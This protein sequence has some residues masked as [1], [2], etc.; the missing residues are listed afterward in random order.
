MSVYGAGGTFTESTDYV[1][2]FEYCRQGTAPRALSH[3]AFSEGRVVNGEFQYDMKDHLGNV[4]LSFKKN[5]S[6]NADIVQEDLYYPFGLRVPLT[7]GDNKYLY[8][9]KE[10]VNKYDLNWYHYGA[11][12]YDPQL[13]RWHTMDPADQFQSPYEYVGNDPATVVDPDGAQATNAK[14]ESLPSLQ[15]M[16]ETYQFNQMKAEGFNLSLDFK[17]ASGANLLVDFTQ[18]SSD[19]SFSLGVGLFALGF[20]TDGATWPFAEHAFAASLYASAANLGIRAYENNWVLDKT[21]KR[22]A[23]GLVIS[24]GVGVGA[25]QM[26]ERLLMRSVGSKADALATT[27][28][29]AMVRSLLGLYAEGANAL[30]NPAKATFGTGASREAGALYYAIPDRTATQQLKLPSY[31]TYRQR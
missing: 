13:A 14:G 15:Q 16:W 23:L 20:M 24:V 1:G 26:T 10:L 5:S 18:F 12:Y 7:T 3:F 11:R 25:S 30:L 8:N 22:D 4:R 27:R 28:E 6:G 29:A 21:M 19:V 2:G 17:G 9:G 31:P